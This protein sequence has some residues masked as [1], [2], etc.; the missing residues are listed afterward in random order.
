MAA[1][2]I[3]EYIALRVRQDEKA[4]DV[5]IDDRLVA[6]VTRMFDRCFTDGE[7]KQALGVAIESRRLD[8]I[9]RAITQSSKLIS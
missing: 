3:D 5:A 8:I 7:Y 6:I 9:E 2:C 1:K 4:E